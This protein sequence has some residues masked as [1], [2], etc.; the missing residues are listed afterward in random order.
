MGTITSNTLWDG[1]RPPRGTYGTYPSWK[2]GSLSS[3]KDGSLSSKKWVPVLLEE[4][5]PCPPGRVGTMSPG[6]MDTMS[7][8][9]PKGS[10]LSRGHGTYPS[11][12]LHLPSLPDEKISSIPPFIISNSILNLTYT[13]STSNL[14][15]E[16]RTLFFCYANL[17]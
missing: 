17:A 2:D 3:W 16:V 1:F 10:H 5:V 7:S 12:T 9:P 15:K 13:Y 6:M 11:R 14:Y 4:Q 8:C